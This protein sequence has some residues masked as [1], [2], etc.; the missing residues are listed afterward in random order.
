[1]R[2]GGGEGASA[3]ATAPVE[4]HG[5]VV[6][7]HARR[8]DLPAALEAVQ[9][10]VDGGGTPDARMC[11][12]PAGMQHDSAVDDTHQRWDAHMSDTRDQRACR[13]TWV[14]LRQHRKLG[15]LLH[16]RAGAPGWPRALRCLS[17][18]AAKTLSPQLWRLRYSDVVD[19]AMRCGDYQ[20]A[21]QVETRIDRTEHPRDV[22]QVLVTKLPP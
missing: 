3:G 10:F 15:A 6:A 11:G 18:P 12:P 22:S 13:V 4:A 2:D 21:L 1:M 5:A 17:L 7:G 19:L 8:S 14:E 9:R 16:A 20:Q